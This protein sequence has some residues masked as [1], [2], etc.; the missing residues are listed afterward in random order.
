MFLQFKTPLEESQVELAEQI[1]TSAQLALDGGFGLPFPVVIVLT[2]LFAI[3]T[4]INLRSWPCGQPFFSPPSRS[5]LPFS[6][7]CVRNMAFLTML[8]PPQSKTERPPTA[9]CIT[10]H[11]TTGGISLFKTSNSVKIP[12]NKQGE[13][14]MPSPT[15]ID[16]EPIGSP[17]AYNSQNGINEGVLIMMAATGVFWT[18]VGFLTVRT[19]RRRHKS[20]G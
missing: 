12:P 9:V 15:H 18:M 8:T 13:I 1:K 10:K 19:I 3:G 4:Y 2:A 7:T 6:A 16:T 5:F 17:G 20:Q 11:Y 14:K